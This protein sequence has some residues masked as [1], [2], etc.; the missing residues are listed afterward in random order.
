M[1][2][3]R[4]FY[5]CIALVML[6][7][8]MPVPSNGQCPDNNC[9]L[10]PPTIELGT[11]VRV[12]TGFGETVRTPKANVAGPV[13]SQ[14]VWTGC[15]QAVYV[16]DPETGLIRKLIRNEL[17]SST[18]GGLAGT[19]KYGDWQEAYCELPGAQSYGYKTGEWPRPI[20]APEVLRLLG[21]GIVNHFAADRKV[22]M[23]ETYN[24][25]GYP[26]SIIG[27]EGRLD[28]NLWMLLPAFRTT[29]QQRLPRELE[30]TGRID[31]TR[32]Y[33]YDKQPKPLKEAIPSPRRPRPQRATV[34]YA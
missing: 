32:F 18:R 13:R 30:D 11:P 23:S 2:F 8:C 12:G 34:A 25:T 24:L 26:Y 1:K 17:R 4:F 27:K 28:R 33:R 5:V 10:Q 19:G 21:N 20:A 3:H 6:V 31:S 9:P 7:G 15:F 16:P 14:G 29:V 22:V